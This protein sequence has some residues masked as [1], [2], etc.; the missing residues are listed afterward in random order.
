MEYLRLLILTSPSLRSK[1]F[2][3]EFF[4]GSINWLE[5]CHVPPKRIFEF[6]D[7]Y[8]NDSSFCL[9]GQK[10]V[11]LPILA[12]TLKQGLIWTQDPDGPSFPIRGHLKVSP[13]P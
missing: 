12:F 8:G 1:N 3:K 7:F 6:F 4:I 9:R 11:K 10:A 2:K 5:H 13:R